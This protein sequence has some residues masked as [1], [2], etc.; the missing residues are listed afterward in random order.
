MAVK[1]NF[2]FSVE[3]FQRSHLLQKM[4][5]KHGT[6]VVCDVCGWPTRAAWSGIECTQPGCRWTFCY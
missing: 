4:V 2:E 3:L 5:E 1:P 6:R